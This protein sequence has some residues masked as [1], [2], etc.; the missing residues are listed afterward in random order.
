MQFAVIVI[1]ELLPSVDVDDYK[2]AVIVAVILAFLNAFV[3]PIM[4]I[5]TLPVTVLSFGLFLLVI[6][7]VIIF[8][9]G[10]LVDGFSV[11]GWISGYYF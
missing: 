6:N 2:T 1:A 11:D 4:V 9:A 3:K 8:M 7:A 5:F 10:S